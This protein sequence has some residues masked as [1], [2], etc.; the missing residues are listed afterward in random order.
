MDPQT[1]PT[2]PVMD[3]AAPPRPA[4]AAAPVQSAPASSPVPN[5]PVASHQPVAV[6]PAPAVEPDLS[7]T[8]DQSRLAA[9]EPA[10]LLSASDIASTPKKPAKSQPAGPH[11]P[12]A[13]I[14]VAVLVML[15]LCG[16]AILVYITS[17]P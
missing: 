16:I 13:L 5:I 15:G 3:I 2:K 17:Q 4:P 7:G 8:G 12:V 1:H 10:P 6:A 11:A 14:T 9:T